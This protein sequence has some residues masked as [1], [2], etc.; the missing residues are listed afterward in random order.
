MPSKKDLLVNKLASLQNLAAQAGARK[1]RLIEEGNELEKVNEKLK[2]ISARE[3][4]RIDERR[5]KIKDYE[6]QEKDVETKLDKATKMLDVVL[7]SVAEVKNNNAVLILDAEKEAKGIITDGKNKADKIIFDAE[8][9]IIE[10]KHETA[11]IELKAKR[12][13]EQ[14]RKAEILAIENKEKAEDEFNEITE[15]TKGLGHLKKEV[16]ESESKLVKLDRE[17][18]DREDNIRRL[19]VAEKNADAA[20]EIAEKLRKKEEMDA[21]KAIAG[22]LE[23]GKD[24]AELKDF[25]AQLR[26]IYKLSKVPYPTD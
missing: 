13:V 19:K 26:D 5:E 18:N 8:E 16:E 1:L 24:M 4:E 11:K 10:V 17:I 25:E 7:S 15:K 6:K 12:T 14:S 2:I 23:W 9:R 22:R 21:E 20:A 3:N